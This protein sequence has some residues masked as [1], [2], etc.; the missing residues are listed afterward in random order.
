[1]AAV[2]GHGLHHW[3]AGDGV[4]RLV[5]LCCGLPL[6]LVYDAGSWLAEQ[7]NSLISLAGWLILWPAW[8]LVRLVVRPISALG[9]RRREYEADAAVRASGRGEALHRGLSFLGELEPGRSGWDRALASTHPPLELRLEAL[10]TP[11][12]LADVSG[13]R[14][15]DPG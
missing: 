11:S 5:V 12:D 14:T 2:L 10:E 3:A 1:M 7:S 4:S 15:A 9:S 8:V 13:L 6:A